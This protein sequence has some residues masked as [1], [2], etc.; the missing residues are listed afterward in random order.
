MRNQAH[1]RERKSWE[2]RGLQRAECIAESGIRL[3]CFKGGRET[4]P[5]RN[6]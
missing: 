5:D 4:V 3:G 1:P 2:V 6:E